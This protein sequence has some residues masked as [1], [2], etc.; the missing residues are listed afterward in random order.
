[1]NSLQQDEGSRTT[2]R[3]SL[4]MEVLKSLYQ[5]LATQSNNVYKFIQVFNLAIHLSGSKQWIVA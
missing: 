3:N 1:M 4:R 2:L 5:S